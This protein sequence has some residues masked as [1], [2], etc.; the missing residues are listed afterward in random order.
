M[1]CFD[2]IAWLTQNAASTDGS[3]SRN[4][5][6]PKTTIFAH[7][8]GRRFG[9]AVKLARIIPVEYS[10]VTTRT[11]S[12]PIASCER[13]TPASAMSSGCRSA[14]SRR[15]M[16]PQWDEVTAAKIAGRPI[17]STTAAKSDQRVERSE[18]SFVHSE[19]ITRSCVTRP[20]CSSRGMAGAA[21][22]LTPPP[23]P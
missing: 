8:T 4:E 17:V 19:T 16:W 18:W 21:T 1:S 7:S 9:T 3:M 23:Q 13:L 11:P 5:T 10:P 15:L 22:L 20:V 12:T 14:R 2:R 6:T